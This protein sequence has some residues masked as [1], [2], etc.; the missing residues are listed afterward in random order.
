MIR[1]KFRCWYVSKREDGTES[2]RLGAVVGTEGD[3]AEWSKATPN[4]LLEMVISNPSAQGYFEQGKDYY[5]N[6][7]R[8]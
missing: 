8:V 7:E 5:L 1:A 6:I 3:N 2:V 4:G